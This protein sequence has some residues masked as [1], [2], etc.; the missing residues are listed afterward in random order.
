MGILMIVV[1]EAPAVEERGV[2]SFVDVPPSLKHL[3]EKKEKVSPS[4]Q[5]F[6]P[7]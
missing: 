1:E 6:Q 3:T 5:P 7:S 4:Y 2:E